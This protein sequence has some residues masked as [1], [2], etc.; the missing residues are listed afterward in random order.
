MRISDWSSDVCSSDLGLDRAIATAFTDLVIDKNAAGRVGVGAP[1]AAPTLFGGTG[2]IVN[3]HCGAFDLAQFTLD[4][5]EFVAMVNGWIAHQRNAFVFF[6]FV[7][8]DHDFACA[9]STIGRA[10][11]RERV[12]QYV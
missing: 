8:D 2:L 4:A 3:Q 5:I 1:F 6:G 11:C 9:F 12:C 10:S 7:S